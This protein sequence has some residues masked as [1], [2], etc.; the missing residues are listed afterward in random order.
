MG[1][2]TTSPLLLSAVLVTTVSTTGDPYS[3]SA[4]R[5][6]PSRSVDQLGVLR[7]YVSHTIADSHR[8][9]RG[10]LHLVLLSPLFPLELL[11]LLVL[12]TPKFK[13]GSGGKHAH[14]RHPHGQARFAGMKKLS[15]FGIRI[16]VAAFDNDFKEVDI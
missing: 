14:N 3:T 12:A 9:V 8:L 10:V 13:F 1:L 2:T 4:F 11:L 7:V 6:W 15:A 5:H 16:R